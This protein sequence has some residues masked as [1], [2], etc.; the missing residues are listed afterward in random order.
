MNRSSTRFAT[1]AVGDRIH[2]N[3]TYR[4]PTDATTGAAFS[5]T[6]SHGGPIDR[7]GSAGHDGGGD[8]VKAVLVA[9]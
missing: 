9:I 1:G 6:D 4:K 2:F 5:N 3:A 8:R 7:S